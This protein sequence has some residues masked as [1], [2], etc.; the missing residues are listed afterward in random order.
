MWKYCVTIA[1]LLIVNHHAEGEGSCK[2]KHVFVCNDG[3]CIPRY[4]RCDGHVTCADGED[5]ENCG[6]TCH[7]CANRWIDIDNGECLAAGRYT[8]TC[9]GDEVCKST[10]KERRGKIV[11]SAKGCFPKDKCER[12]QKKNK[13]GCSED[14]ISM[15]KR[16]TCTICCDTDWC[17]DPSRMEIEHKPAKSRK[18]RFMD[19]E[20]RD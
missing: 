19:I 6:P 12:K 4:L 14:V 2:G 16:M 1:I 20:H 17:N 10:I 7:R 9:E 13:R 8:I 15:A 5:E 18:P 11:Y 3:T